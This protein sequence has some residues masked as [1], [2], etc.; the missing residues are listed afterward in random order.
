MKNY[1]RLGSVA[2]VLG[3]TAAGMALSAGTAQAASYNGACGSGYSVIDSMNVV[4]GTVYLTYNAS[5]G[6]NCVVTVTNT[7]GTP[8][9]MGANLRLSRNDNVWTST[10][11]DSGTYS[12][13]AGP[14]YK[15]APNSCIDWGGRVASNYT[16]I[17]YDDHCG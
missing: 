4:D 8:D 14:L 12:Y 3:L 7:P 10:E 5:N 17:N 9:V 13:Y 2:A 1:K 15:Y 6:Y 11:E 16:R